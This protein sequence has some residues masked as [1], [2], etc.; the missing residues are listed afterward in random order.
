MLAARNRW[1]RIAAALTGVSWLVLAA[2]EIIE[3]D[4]LFQGVVRGGYNVSAVLFV[5]VHLVGAWGFFAIALAFGA[6]IDWRRLRFGAT[7]VASVYIAYFGAWVFRTIAVY[8]D[9]TNVDTRSYYVWGAAGALLF[10]I[11]AWIAVSGLAEGR[12]GAPRASRL[13]RGA[14]LLVVSAVASTVGL[15]FL[16]ASLSGFGSPRELTLGLLFEAVGAFGL[17][18]AALVFFYGARRPFPAREA[19]LTSAAKVAVVASLC[20]LLGEVLYASGYSNH[21]APAWEQVTVWLAVA[22][23]VAFVLALTAVALGARAAR[24]DSAL[25]V[26]RAA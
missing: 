9:T 4:H 24:D 18:V 14:I 20:V 25:G 1:F 11:G 23:Q 17:G 6:E 10:A 12:R 8:A 5:A 16:Q 3:A 13:R 7:I 19:S 2:L 22:G 15:G 21:A 26:A